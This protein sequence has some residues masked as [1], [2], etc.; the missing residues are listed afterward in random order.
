[1]YKDFHFDFDLILFY[2]AK[3]ETKK[4]MIEKKRHGK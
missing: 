4:N 1:M 2:K 3:N